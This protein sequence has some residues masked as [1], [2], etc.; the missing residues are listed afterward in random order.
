MKKYPT[1]FLLLGLWL[2]A[3]GSPAW[4]EDTKLGIVDAQK[5]F[6][7]SKVGK[8]DKFFL[9][10]YVKT[11]QRLLES[12]EADLKQ[13]QSDLQKQQAVLT[14][15][16]M[17]QKSEEFRQRV[18]TYQRHVQEMQGEV[19]A[20]KR[21]L[22][23]V[24]SKKIE[25]VVAEIAAKERILLVLEKGAGSVGTMVLFNTPSIDITDQVIKALDSKAGN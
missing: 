5:I 13:L 9:E 17:Q 7:G 4:A 2:L 6:E 22:L 25:Q 1:I 18:E 11:R 19:E 20:K 24:F 15:G 10:D 16:A 8:K 23:G 3:W 14:P 21:E 12:E